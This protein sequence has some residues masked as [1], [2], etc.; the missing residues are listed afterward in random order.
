MDHAGSREI[1]S[2]KARRE[3][4]FQLWNPHSSTAL[5][6]PREQLS[7]GSITL[8][9]VQIAQKLRGSQPPS[10]TDLEDKIDQSVELA[11]GYGHLDERR[12]AASAIEKSVRKTV[13]DLRLAGSADLR[14]AGSAEII[15]KSTEVFLSEGVFS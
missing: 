9:D 5:Y 6:D 13:Y 3:A 2:L 14:L 12:T 1:A 8:A 15:G 11:L 4:E 7:G 10:C